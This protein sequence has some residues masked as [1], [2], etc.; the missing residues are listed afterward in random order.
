MLSTSKHGRP[1]DWP[2]VAAQVHRMSPD[3]RQGP[4]TADFMPGALQACLSALG[5]KQ[6]C[7][8]SELSKIPVAH[9]QQ[10][11]SS[12]VIAVAV[13]CACMHSCS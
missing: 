5:L 8:S 10:Q 11:Q 7:D 6:P 9:S 4:G 1:L 2:A 12:C 13:M 3:L